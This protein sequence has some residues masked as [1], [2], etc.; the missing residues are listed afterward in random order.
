MTPIL[1]FILA[2]SSFASSSRLFCTP[3]LLFRLAPSRAL[4]TSL[5]PAVL[6]AALPFT[7]SLAAASGSAAARALRLPPDKAFGLRLR[8]SGLAIREETAFELDRRLSRCVC[9]TVRLSFL[10]KMDEVGIL[11]RLLSALPLKAD[12]V[13]GGVEVEA[14]FEA[15]AEARAARARMGLRGAYRKFVSSSI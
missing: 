8:F 10:L 14:G 2:L 7:A 4:L 11:L 6:L 1:P 3:L 5:T 9:F 15:A 13:A 12:E